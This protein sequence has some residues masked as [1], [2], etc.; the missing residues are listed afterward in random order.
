M[1][2]PSVQ[3]AKML[4][5]LALQKSMELFVA[6]ACDQTR[7]ADRQALTQMHSRGQC[8]YSRTRTQQ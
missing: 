1:S 4:R 5:W 2:E 7:S 6:K 3:A 8:L